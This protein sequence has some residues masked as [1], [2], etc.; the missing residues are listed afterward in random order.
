MRLGLGV[1][2]AVDHFR[3]DRVHLWR[4]IR[5]QRAAI[6]AQQAERLGV[7]G[8]VAGF[9]KDPIENRLFGP[10]GRGDSRRVGTDV[11]L[12]P[13]LSRFG[14]QRAG[15]FGDAGDRL[16]RRSAGHGTQGGDIVCRRDGASAC[17]FVIAV[18]IVA[19]G[20]VGGA[21]FDSASSRS[22][23]RLRKSDERD[24]E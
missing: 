19:I 14:R 24:Q 17:D 23:T 2:E 11:V 12:A 18:G 16:S 21:P 20:V 4:V 8:F 22:W 9:T 10:A 13:F 15:A 1:D 7:P 6:G 5:D 3:D